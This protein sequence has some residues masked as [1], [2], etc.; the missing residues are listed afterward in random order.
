MSEMQFSQMLT[1]N[2]TI[3][4]RYTNEILRKINL[5]ICG[6]NDSIHWL[7]IASGGDSHGGDLFISFSQTRFLT[8]GSCIPIRIF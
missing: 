3:L 7:S 8:H 5:C 1:Q 2:D 4:V 6:H